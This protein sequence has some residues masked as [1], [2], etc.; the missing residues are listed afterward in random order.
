MSSELLI[1]RHQELER[2]ITGIRELL[3]QA[4]VLDELLD[5]FKVLCTG[6]TDF[7]PITEGI[8]EAWTLK[9]GNPTYAQ[10]FNILI[11]NTRQ[12]IELEKNLG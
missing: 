10:L 3:R 9:G 6:S 1:E 5:I 8:M 11:E 4:E 7:R 2:Q 12:K